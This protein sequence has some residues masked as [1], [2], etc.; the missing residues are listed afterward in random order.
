VYVIALVEQLGF[1]PVVAAQF[2]QACPDM[3][4]GIAAQVGAVG[5]AP[6]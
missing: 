6:N 4:D 2:V 5:D 1:W 3:I